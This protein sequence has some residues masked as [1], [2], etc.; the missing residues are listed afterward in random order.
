M[1]A[2]AKHCTQARIA[3]PHCPWRLFVPTEPRLRPSWQVGFTTVHRSCP[4][5]GDGPE[6]HRAGAL[7]PL[8]IRDEAREDR[9]AVISLRSEEGVES[10]SEGEALGEPARTGRLQR[11]LHTRD[12]D[13]CQSCP[14]KQAPKGRFVGEAELCGLARWRRSGSRNATLAASKRVISS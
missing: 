3:D 2:H 13:R 8:Q 10:W 11:S 5:E 4:D 12:C 1:P 9:R 14:C 7:V 6:A